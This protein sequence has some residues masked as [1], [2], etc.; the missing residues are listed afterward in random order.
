MRLL[1]FLFA[2]CPFAWAANTTSGG[3]IVC[4]FA[5]WSHKRKGNGSF[6]VSDIDA[7]ICS[8]FIWSF[9]TI[10]EN[11]IAVPNRNGSNGI[12]EF[13]ALR[14]RNPRAKFLVAVGGAKNSKGPKYSNM[15]SSPRSRGE[16]IN[17]SVDFLKQYN[18]DGLDMDWEYPTFHGGVPSDREN[19]VLL[20]KELK[21]RFNQEG[22]YLLTAALAPNQ[23]VAAKAYDIPGISQHVDFINLMTYNFYG[24]WKTHTGHPARLQG[25][26]EISVDSSVKYWLDGGTPK[27]KL[28]IGVPT[29]GKSWTLSDPNNHDV[30]APTSGVGQPG[31]YT[32]TPGT[33]AYNEFCE[34]INAGQWTVE[35]D[36]QA[37]APYAYK[38][39]QWIGY[40]NI[41]SAKDKANFIRNSELGG[42]MIWTIDFDDFR[43]R[44]GEKYGILRG[45]NDVLRN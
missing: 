41:Q 36:Q 45:L 7:S 20:L 39:D 16:F 32:Q 38:G 10:Q 21:E 34:Q 9:A 26:G 5:S 11:E 35:F 13:V 14:S 17:S 33:L 42:A 24:A 23:R 8:H 31:P 4:Y 3:K 40:E 1:I 25:S 22:G 12:R 2:L 44:C 29:Y 15:V 18:L 37:K 28:V 19:F 43:G 6:T 27:E 30:G